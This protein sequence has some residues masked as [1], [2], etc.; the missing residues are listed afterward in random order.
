MSG[1]SS[2]MPTRSN[3]WVRNVVPL[4]TLFRILFG[5]VWIVA[6]ALKFSS[7]FVSNFP[8]AVQTASGNAPGWLSGW[9]SFWLTQ[10]N[11]NAQLIVYSVGGLELVLGI[12][13]VLG[14]LRKVAYLGGVLL[15]LLIWAVPEGFGGPYGSGAGGTDVGAG[16][17]YALLFLG[18]IVINST[19]GPSRFSLD[20]LIERRVRAWSRLAEF[21]ASD[22]MAPSKSSAISN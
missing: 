17:V 8:A 22:T 3:W 6:G 1:P 13:L 15:S 11:A 7:G 18:L 16:V 5:V 2:S 12:A 10:A 19:F 9:Y 4:K 21:A 20:Y 14:L